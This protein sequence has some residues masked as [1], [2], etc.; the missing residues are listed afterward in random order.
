MYKKLFELSRLSN[1]EICKALDMGHTS[2]IQYEKA[3]KISVETFVNFSRKLG[4]ADK[5]T[6]LLVVKEM[7]LI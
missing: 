4:I 2:R 7:K 6:V 1:H 5:D 3:E